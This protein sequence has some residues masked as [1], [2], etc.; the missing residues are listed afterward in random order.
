MCEEIKRNR[1]HKVDSHMLFASG[2]SDLHITYYRGRVFD[3]YCFLGSGGVY[4]GVG[5]M[6]RLSV[7]LGGN[8]K[9]MKDCIKRRVKCMKLSIKWKSTV[10]STTQ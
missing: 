3:F 5:Y 7:M 6:G 10:D 4:S 2:Q 8:M 9:V 1:T